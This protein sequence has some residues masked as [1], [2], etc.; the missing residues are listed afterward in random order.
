ML[1]CQLLHVIL[2][3]SHLQI[4]I[5]T[6]SSIDAAN[7][8]SMSDEQPG[9]PDHCDWNNI[10]IDEPSPLPQ[11]LDDLSTKFGSNLWLISAN[12][13]EHRAARC[14]IAKETL[15][16]LGDDR[17][18]RNELPAYVEKVEK[19][20]KNMPLDLSPDKMTSA[21][22][23][24]P[25]MRDGGTPG[26]ALE[27]STTDD[28]VIDAAIKLA[29]ITGSS[30]ITITNAAAAGHVCGGF[31]KGGRHALEECI[32]TA[33]TVSRALEDRYRTATK[34]G[35]EYMPS[36]NVLLTSN[37]KLFRT[38]TLTR[39]ALNKPPLPVKVISAAMPNFNTRVS[40]TAV[41]RLV[42]KT[43]CGEGTESEYCKHI[44]NVWEA[45]LAAA[46][47]AQNEYLVLADIGCGVFGND[48][49]SVG[50]ALGKALRKFT[51]KKRG[52]LKHI[53]LAGVQKI[54]REQGTINPGQANAE[55]AFIAA[56]YPPGKCFPVKRQDEER[57]PDVYLKRV[58]QEMD[59]FWKARDAQ[60][61]SIEAAAASV[62]GSDLGKM[63]TTGINDL[64]G[65]LES[66][67]RDIR[68]RVEALASPSAESPSAS[69]STK[70][71]CADI[72]CNARRTQCACNRF[73][74][75]YGNCCDDYQNVCVA[76]GGG[77]RSRSAAPPGG[78]RGSTASQGASRERAVPQGEIENLQATIRQ[79]E[80]KRQENQ[81]LL[82]AER[83][84]TQKAQAEAQEIKAKLSREEDK[85][86]KA[87]A[88]AQKWK[89]KFQEGDIIDLDADIFDADGDDLPPDLVD[90]ASSEESVQSPPSSS[91]P[92]FLNPDPF[93][94][95]DRQGFDTP[96]ARPAAKA[97]PGMAPPG[98]APRGVSPPGMSSSGIAPP[99][100]PPPGTAPQQ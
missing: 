7:E 11:T 74:N 49:A 55:I 69:T 89:A 68:G 2:F 39:Y 27:F 60:K 80:A 61:G 1:L 36:P 33:T 59:N 95:D 6:E 12:G 8:T 63:I 62:M 4:A 71:R 56:N 21:E 66:S 88:S 77:G 45:V 86:V 83:Q 3:L 57:R 78:P 54:G 30:E 16:L 41:T 15:F 90:D 53:V 87:I 32:C 18:K 52:N 13:P 72:G 94:D 35:R 48:P 51:G 10:R 100:M 29:A 28:Y 84:K 97:P 92:K 98:M 17:G 14:R 50:F 67:M 47:E 91:S 37:V 99:D 20:K 43:C 75:D 82:K 64:G 40:D 34:S 9:Q 58:G 46:V 25:D 76:G 70:P 73:C 81:S 79:L 24:A 96:E 19:M 85:A 38:G 42:K 26:E 5:R 44:R 23:K 22:V 93:A 65:H 31:L